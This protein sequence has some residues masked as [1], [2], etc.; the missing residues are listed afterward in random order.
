[1]TALRSSAAACRPRRHTRFDRA[2]LA[3]C[4]AL[5]DVLGAQERTQTST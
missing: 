3:E 1:M 4:R 2:V 5:S